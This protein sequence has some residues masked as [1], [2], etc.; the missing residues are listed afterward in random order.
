MSLKRTKRQIEAI[1]KWEKNNRKGTLQFSTGVGKTNTAIIAIKKLL[2]EDW[3][4]STHIIVPTLYLKGQWEEALKQA[5]IM[6][7]Q[8]RTQVFVINTYLKWPHTCDLLILDEI[9]NYGSL[10]RLQVFKTEYKRILGLTATIT[11]KDQTH[12]IIQS[13]APIV[14]EINLREAQDENYVADFIVYNLGIQLSETDRA[15]LNSYNKEF[16]KHFA[17]FG[18]DFNLAMKCMSD[19]KTRERYAKQTGFQEKQIA[20]HAVRFNHFMQK[21]KNFLYNVDAK[22]EITEEIISR[23]WKRKVITF[24]ENT[25]FADALPGL[26]YHSKI[27]KKDRKLTLERFKDNN[28]SSNPNDYILNTSKALDEGFDVG[29]IELAIITSSRAVK[30]VDIQRTGRAIRFKPGKLAVVVNVYIK[31]SKDE[32]WLRQRQEKSNNIYWID[33]VNDIKFERPQVASS[34]ADSRWSNQYSID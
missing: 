9:H 18:H 11:R 22:R 13:Y 15:L 23:H 5:N 31:D 25:D 8:G 24:S 21:R 4:A 29:D 32:D 2:K 10:K 33:N 30:R 16:Y 27:S 6:V 34:K 3:T 14:D 17:Y 1:Q 26:S 20:F 12:S 28:F 19:K 7:A